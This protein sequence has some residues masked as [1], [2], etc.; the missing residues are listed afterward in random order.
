L[1]VLAKQSVDQN[2][3]EVMKSKQRVLEA[4]QRDIIEKFGVQAVA[5]AKASKE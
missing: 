1:F 5:A 2:R 3:V 4:R